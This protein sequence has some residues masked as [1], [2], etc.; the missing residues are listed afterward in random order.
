MMIGKMYALLE[1]SQPFGG[2]SVKKYNI[3]YADP[4]WGYKSSM[5]G[6]RGVLNH[7]QTMS[8]QD[9]ASLPVNDIADTD[10]ILFLWVTMPKLNEVFGVIKSWGFE[11]KTVGFTWI[12]LNKK[13]GTPFMGMGRWTRA[14]AEVCLIAT[15]GKPKRLNAGVHSVIMSTIE[16]HSK[17][18]D[19]TRDRIVKLVGDLPRVELFARQKVEGWDSWGN[20]LDN[21]IELLPPRQPSGTEL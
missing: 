15:K 21:D 18:P 13:S 17:K 7:Y 6:D 9:I 2:V 19:E 8:I 14:N 20:E 11:Y 16:G 5:E 10:C 1:N 4:A 3:I 12:K